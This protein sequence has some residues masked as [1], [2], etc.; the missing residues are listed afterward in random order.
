MDKEIFN[1]N[2]VITGPDD[3][4][5]GIIRKQNELVIEFNKKKKIL[6]E[7]EKRRAER[8][9]EKEIEREKEEEERRKRK[10]NKR[11]R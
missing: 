8:E 7:K 6:E 9:K 11:R 2:K 5:E 1:V 3:Y 10:K 4:F